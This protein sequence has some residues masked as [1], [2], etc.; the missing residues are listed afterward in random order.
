M[1]LYLF[2][3][4][5][6]TFPAILLIYLDMSLVYIHKSAESCALQEVCSCLILY[7]NGPHDGH[8]LCSSQCAYLANLMHFLCIDE[9]QNI[10][11]QSLVCSTFAKSL[12]KV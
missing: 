11:N 10:C 9:T 2:Q 5:P 7:N 6:F 8:D 4:W 12:L 1:A 3:S